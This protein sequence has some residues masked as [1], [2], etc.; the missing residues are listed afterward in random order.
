MAEAIAPIDFSLRGGTESLGVRSS[1]AD[2]GIR[3]RTSCSLTLRVAF[4]SSFDGLLRQE[5]VDHF[6]VACD[7]GQSL[8]RALVAKCQSLVIDT[9][10]A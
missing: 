6:R 7:I 8:V 10:R 4:L 9:K 1:Q 2:V 5:V 3:L